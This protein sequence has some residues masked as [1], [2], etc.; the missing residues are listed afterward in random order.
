M[1]TT[2]NS[3]VTVVSSPA[4]EEPFGSTLQRLLKLTDSDLNRLEQFLQ[5]RLGCT[6]ADG[7]LV[8]R[9]DDFDGW[10][11]TSGMSGTVPPPTT[12]VR[13]LL[14]LKVFM[15][16]PGAEPLTE[17]KD[18]AYIAQRVVHAAA[19]KN[20]PQQKQQQVTTPTHRPAVNANVNANTNGASAHQKLL[21]INVGGRRFETTRE[22]LC[23]VPGSNLEA[24][25]SGRHENSAIRGPD[26]SYFIDRDGSQFHHVLAFLRMGGGAVLSLPRDADGKKN[27]A[28]EADFYGLDGLAR[29][30]GM[31]PT[32]VLECLDRGAREIWEAEERCRTAFRRGDGP[33]GLAPFHGLLA[34]FSPEERQMKLPLLYRPPITQSDRMVPTIM[35]VRL[36]QSLLAE[37]QAVTVSSLAAFES[38]FNRSH[39]NILHRLR[40]VLLEEPVILAG[41]SVLHAL[42]AGLRPL[43]WWP[44][45][46]D[47]TSLSTPALR[48]K[49]VGSR[50]ASSIALRSTTSIGWFS[51]AT[52]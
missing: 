36:S 31:P 14:L 34:L 1:T 27:L 26:G 33:S 11:C 8:L 4:A 29:A 41:G 52:A 9:E 51:A 17:V 13:K 16:L 38:N 43:E 23:R 2:S 25:F 22:T 24:M 47:V 10:C 7:L 45:V 42:T 50:T 12:T 18:F 5:Q 40:P 48:R 44:T 6:D 39:P 3:P 15:L 28:I 20:P 49:P 35:D 32:D 30:V 19:K 37:G 21:R 46:D